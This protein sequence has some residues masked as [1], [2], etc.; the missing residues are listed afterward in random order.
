MEPIK[1]P[2]TLAPM[3]RRVA[4]IAL[5]FAVTTTVFS[6]CQLPVPPMDTA[7]LPTTVT[8]AKPLYIFTNP[9]SRPA[10]SSALT[11]V[12]APPSP[13]SLPI[14]S[15]VE[16]TRAAICP[17]KH[18]WRSWVVPRPTEVVSPPTTPYPDFGVPSPVAVWQEQ[19]GP[20]VKLDFPRAKGL[21]LLGVVLEGIVTVAP[22]EGSTL[23]A[24]DAW[25]AFSAPGAG[26]AVTADPAAASVLFMAYSLDSTIDKS[27]A[28]LRA[29]D[30][31]VFWD[32]RPGSFAVQDLK[33]AEQLMWAQGTSHAWIGFEPD[34]S[35]HVF[36]GALRLT[37]S[38]TAPPLDN[39]W[40]VLIVL[41]GTATLALSGERVES[42][43]NIAR[44]M[45]L[46]PGQVVTIPSNVAR[47]VNPG[48][49]QPWYAVQLFVPPGPERRYRDLVQQKEGP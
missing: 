27:V 30:K 1:D 32:R 6:A 21:A 47:T 11:I 20:G 37:Q 49:S 34:R 10:S 28:A 31:A 19:L 29:N 33:R 35:P 44:N 48:S 4:P 42:N 8:S 41:Q 7:A 23:A 25:N 43:A 3:P 36:L 17:Q 22:A 18:C 26:V 9:P 12:D 39:G 2:A 15:H 13:A 5:L 38:D 46:Q 16:M 40:E 45:E 24:I 14:L